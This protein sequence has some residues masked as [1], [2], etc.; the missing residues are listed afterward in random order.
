MNAGHT[1][2]I[3][4]PFDTLNDTAIDVAMEMVKELEISDLEPFEIAAMIEEEIS[5]LVPTWKD[6]GASQN[7]RQHS[8]N[9]EEEDDISNHH[10][11]SSSSCSSSHSSLPMVG[12]SSNSQFGVSHVAFTQDWLQGIVFLAK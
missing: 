9:Y 12:L 3:Y 11:S 6:W 7:P 1:R 10:P 5:N 2:N 4:F 8:F